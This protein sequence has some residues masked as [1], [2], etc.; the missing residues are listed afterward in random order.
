MLIAV[1]LVAFGGF[2]LMRARRALNLRP[3]DDKAITAV[4]TS[5]LPAVPATGSI[6]EMPSVTEHTTLELKEPE[7]IR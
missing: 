3:S 6:I 1:P 7:R 5:Q 2:R 4:P